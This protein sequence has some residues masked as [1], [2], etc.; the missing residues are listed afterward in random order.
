M[1]RR[2]VG[3]LIGAL[4]VVVATTVF[5]AGQ[6]ATAKAPAPKETAASAKWTPPRT[7]W[8]DPD[9]QGIWN[10]A[11]TTPME[12]LT[13]EETAAR[14]AV[15]PDAVRRKLVAATGPPAGWSDRGRPTNQA[16]LVVDPPDGR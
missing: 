4:A 7:E 5:V 11:V 9:L 15:Q 1:K 6:G 2:L 16:F 3:S 10:N 12:R 8:G 14:Q 13:D